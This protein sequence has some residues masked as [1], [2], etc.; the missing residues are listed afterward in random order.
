MLPLINLWFSRVN[1]FRFPFHIYLYGLTFHNSR[2]PSYFFFY[3]YG[4]IKIYIYIYII[5]SMVC[6]FTSVGAI[7]CFDCG[8]L[9]ISKVIIIVTLLIKLWPNT[10][11]LYN[12]VYYFWSSQIIDKYKALANC[13]S[14][15]LIIWLLS[16]E[17]KEIL[18]KISA[19]IENLMTARA[20]MLQNI[21]NY[22]VIIYIIISGTF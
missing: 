6:H 20:E 14:E 2:H 9:K 15:E 7:I 22:C 18:I 17:D 4:H 13:Y 12:C 8:Q 10:A 11:N 21:Y 19:C 1:W 16:N 5:L 3:L